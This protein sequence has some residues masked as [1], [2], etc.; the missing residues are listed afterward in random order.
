MTKYLLYDFFGHFLVQ[1]ES[2][3]VGTFIVSDEVDRLEFERFFKNKI[4]TNSSKEG[5]IIMCNVD[6]IRGT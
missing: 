3:M 6:Y 5:E 4:G 2:H 1:F